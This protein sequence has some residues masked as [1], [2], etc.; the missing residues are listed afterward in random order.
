MKKVPI[1]L[2][3]MDFMANSNPFLDF[4]KYRDIIRSIDTTLGMENV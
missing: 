3:R 1:V 2:Q 4:R